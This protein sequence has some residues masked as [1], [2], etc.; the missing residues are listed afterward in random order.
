MADPSGHLEILT[1]GGSGLDY[2]VVVSALLIG[3]AFL[4]DPIAARGDRRQRHRRA[5]TRVTPTRPARHNARYGR[6]GGAASGT[7]VSA[8]PIS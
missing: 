5:G 3:F 2:L 8:S 4:P 6:A 7:T 1:T